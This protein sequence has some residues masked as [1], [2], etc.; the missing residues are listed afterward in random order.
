MTKFLT[1]AATLLALASPAFAGT[2]IENAIAAFE[3]TNDQVQA[4]IVA[5]ACIPADGKRDT[6]EY[7]ETARW[8]LRGGGLGQL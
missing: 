1:T 8:T 6:P 5:D 7:N 4:A 3:G 2:L